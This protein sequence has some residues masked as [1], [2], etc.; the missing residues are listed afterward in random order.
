MKVFSDDINEHQ[1]KINIKNYEKIA[2]N[3]ARQFFDGISEDIDEVL[4]FIKYL[5][6]K[7][8]ILDVACGVGRWSKFFS[9]RGYRVI[10]ID[11]SIKM[12]EEAKKRVADVMFERMDMRKILY[13]EQTFSAVFAA[14]AICYIPRRE[15][16]KVLQNFWKILKPNG[17]LFII[18]YEG[19]G[20]KYYREPLDSAGKS[21]F[22][23]VFYTKE[24]LE[25]QLEN[26]KFDII[27]SKVGK[28]C[29]E[30][31]LKDV[32]KIYILGKRHGGV[33]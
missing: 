14:Y 6:P 3:Y 19:K 27:F 20:V 12:I 16:Q 32:K 21:G 15:L 18:T 1:V 25:K 11:A 13:P 28:P 2:K 4:E 5:P 8:T 33:Q 9:E 23:L 29:S 10:G 22:F 31:I 17:F 7:A 24:E 26:A 30:Q